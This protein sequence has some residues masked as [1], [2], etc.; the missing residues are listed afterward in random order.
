M[1]WDLR[2][3]E[4]REE[5]C[6]ILAV[7]L[8]VVLVVV[9]Q[10]SPPCIK[11]KNDNMTSLSPLHVTQTV[12]PPAQA[13]EVHAVTRVTLPPEPRHVQEWANLDNPGSMNPIS[14]W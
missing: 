6:V 14:R 2:V 13:M 1:P 4:V 5:G 7:V 11:T 12:P 8:A 3:K 9:G 10:L